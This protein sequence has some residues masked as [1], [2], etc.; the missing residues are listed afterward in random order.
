MAGSLAVVG[1]ALCSL[2]GCLTLQLSG[3]RSP[4]VGTPFMAVFSHAVLL[5]HLCPDGP[6]ILVQ[7]YRLYP[8]WAIGPRLS[9][10]G[11]KV[12]SSLDYVSVLENERWVRVLADRL[13]RQDCTRVIPYILLFAM[14]VGDDRGLHTLGKS[15]CR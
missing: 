13:P 15:S 6:T 3:S 9:L 5:L 1:W 12:F 7:N 8:V 11:K 14:L 2:S 4:I 10:P